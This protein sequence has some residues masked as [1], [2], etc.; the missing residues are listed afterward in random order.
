M[1]MT[2]LATIY[3]N[4]STTEILPKEITSH[5]LR[6]G[7]W[8]VEEERYTEKIIMDFENGTLDVPEGTTLRTYLSKV[9]NCDPMRITKKYTGNSSI[10]KRTF[11]P[12]VRSPENVPFIDMSQRELE[13]LRRNWISK[14]L[15]AEQ[16]NHR[17]LSLMKN[18]KPFFSKS[19]DGSNHSQS[20]RLHPSGSHDDDLD[21]DDEDDHNRESQVKLREDTISNALKPFIA[22]PAKIS[23]IL[24]WLKTSCAA[25]NHPTTSLDEIDQLIQIGEISVP[26]LE[27]V[28]KTAGITSASQIESLHKMLTAYADHRPHQNGSDESD[29]AYEE[30][31]PVRGKKSKHEQDDY[32]GEDEPKRNKKIE[33][34]PP[35]H[36]ALTQ[37][38]YSFYYTQLPVASNSNGHVNNV[39]EN[40]KKSRRK[41][42]RENPI[43]PTAAAAMTAAPNTAAYPENYPVY[44]PTNY[45]YGYSAPFPTDFMNAAA[46]RM[47]SY[48]DYLH[49]MY[50]QQKG[51]IPA[52]TPVLPHHPAEPLYDSLYLRQMN[53]WIASRSRQNSEDLEAYQSVLQQHQQS[54]PAA[55]PA[56]KAPVSSIDTTKTAANSTG[57]SSSAPL[58]QS[59]RSTGVDAAVVTPTMSLKTSTSSG[60]NNSLTVSTKVSKS[61]EDSMSESSLTKS[62]PEKQKEPSDVVNVGPPTKKQKSAEN[63]SKSAENVPTPVKQEP[64]E[65]P[66]KKARNTKV[67]NEAKNVLHPST[68]DALDTNEGSIEFAAEALLGLQRR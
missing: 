35:Q 29:G 64:S 25:L 26:A 49:A 22:D 59:N 1:E 54:M 43:S 8:T 56:K 17:K 14:L 21:G 20:P 60:S 58:T 42:D 16:W 37:N 3:G 62:N 45:L 9:L 52:A 40:D 27:K 6:R 12:L 47:P 63:S 41:R 11:T 4:G 34:P 18:G 38:P 61:N 68:I 50:L 2:G 10:G 33:S 7:K 46:M 23:Y 28:L 57:P 36:P 44:F 31:R 19:D 67:K 5:T 24:N 13:E 39:V 30:D 65:K 51:L 66:V 15:L 48:Q 55:L 32:V 53:H